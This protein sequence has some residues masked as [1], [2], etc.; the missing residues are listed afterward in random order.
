MRTLGEVYQ[1]TGRYAQAEPLYR[2][3]A[4]ILKKTLGQGSL[5]YAGA[6]F[7]LGA[8][9]AAMKRA[10]EAS[11]SLLEE[12]QVGWGY[13]PAI[14]PR[15]LTS[16]RDSFWPGEHLAEPAPLEPDLP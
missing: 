7:D 13:L 11:A 4:E 1:L 3:A 14:S 6:L 15:C 12:V 9:L 16:R 10:P 5:P 8:T 2:Q